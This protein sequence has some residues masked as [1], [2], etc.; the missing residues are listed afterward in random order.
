MKLFCSVL[1]VSV[2]PRTTRADTIFVNNFSSGTLGEY[3]TSGA[4][5]NSSLISGLTDPFGLAL[6]GSDLFVANEDALTIGIA[7]SGS[8]LLVSNVGIGTVG[9]YTTSGATVNASLISGLGGPAGLAVSGSNLFVANAVAGTISEYNTSGALVNAAL[10]SGLNTP[11][12]I[13][14]SGPDLFVTEE[15]SGTVGE[16]TTSGA[17]VNASLI[18][19]LNVPTGITILPAA[20]VPEPGAGTL[21]LLGM[22]GLVGLAWRRRRASN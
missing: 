8:N 19:G 4:T 11:V 7:L 13:A 1:V 21:T 16:Y 9:E 10:I 17:V 15:G 20:A 6:S 3:T 12:G 2:L 5:I 14:V 18:S 22:A